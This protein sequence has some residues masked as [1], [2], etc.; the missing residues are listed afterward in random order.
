LLFAEGV[1]RGGEG[2]FRGCLVADEPERVATEEVEV[3]TRQLSDKIEHERGERGAQPQHDRQAD[4]RGMRIARVERRAG[5]VQLELGRG[6]GC[7]LSVPAA[8]VRLRFG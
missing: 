6:R 5:S 2:A 7:G 1:G 8:A 3:R 4:G